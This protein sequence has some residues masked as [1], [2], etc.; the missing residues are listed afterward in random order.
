MDGFTR[1]AIVE[2]LV[3]LGAKVHTCARNQTQVDERIR[4]WKAKGFNV[5]GSVCDLKSKEQREQ[6][7]K[8][9]S[10]VFDGK[11]NIL[12]S[13]PP[14]TSH[15]YQRK[16]VTHFLYDYYV[17]TDFKFNILKKYIIKL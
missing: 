11:L 10:S 14:P 6:L 13:F 17:R 12:V 15:N 9:V 2:E 7:I 5:S 4:D 1:Y 16:I 3:G 8:T